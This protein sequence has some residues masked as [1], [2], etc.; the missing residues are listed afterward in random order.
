LS[1]TATPYGKIDV[2]VSLSSSKWFNGDVNYDGD[3]DISDYGI[4]DFNIGIPG[5]PL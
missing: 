4:L 5:A 3:I 2:N 1:A